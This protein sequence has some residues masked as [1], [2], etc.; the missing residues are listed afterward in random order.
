MAHTAVRVV[1]G[2]ALVLTAA[3]LAGCAQS[4]DSLA[5]DNLADDVEHAQDALWEFR[6]Q[7]ARDP[8]AA[9]TGLDFVADARAGAVDGASTYTLVDLG[10]AA[11]DA[12]LTIVVRGGATTGGGMWAEQAYALTCVDFVFPR[13]VDEIRVE[14]AACADILDV[15][16]VRSDE[17]IVP[18]REL[19]VREAVTAADYPPPICQCHS[20]GD[21]DCPGG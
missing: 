9:V 12:T 8:E 11:D 18:F 3:A 13:A 2:I 21:C 6:D 15:L 16:D 19:E 5:R 20:G 4:I 14:E 7:I 17:E 10:S 1:A